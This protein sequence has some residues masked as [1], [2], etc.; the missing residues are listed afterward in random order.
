VTAATGNE[1]ALAQVD[2]AIAAWT[3]KEGGDALFSEN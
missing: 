2:Q 1:K 3:G